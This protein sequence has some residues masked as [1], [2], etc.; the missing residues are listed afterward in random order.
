MGPRAATRVDVGPCLWLQHARRVVR[1]QQLAGSRLPQPRPRRLSRGAS[2]HLHDRS[3]SWP[4]EALVVAAAARHWQVWNVG[5][6]GELHLP[7]RVAAAT[8]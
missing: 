5:T 8:K 3:L 4:R 2:A 7:D 6:G 1:A